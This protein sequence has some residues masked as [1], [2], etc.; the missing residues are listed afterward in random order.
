VL[1]EPLS[2]YLSNVHRYF[3]V[4]DRHSKLDQI[5][6]VTNEIYENSADSITASTKAE[7]KGIAKKEMVRFAG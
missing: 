6:S 1:L 2:I 7:S 3:K 4:I 5:N